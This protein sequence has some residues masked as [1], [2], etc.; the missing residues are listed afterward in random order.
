MGEGEWLTQTA[1]T[2][3]MRVLFKAGGDASQELVFDKA[4]PT[5]LEAAAGPSLA[6]CVQAGGDRGGRRLRRPFENSLM[7]AGGLWTT[8]PDGPWSSRVPASL[9]PFESRPMR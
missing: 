8:H 6:S 2:D 4:V 3:Q 7:T 5:G 9:R 1:N